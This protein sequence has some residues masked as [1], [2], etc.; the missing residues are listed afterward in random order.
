MFAVFHL[1]H[2]S[3]PF[4]I[5]LCEYIRNDC[6]KFFLFTLPERVVQENHIRIDHKLRF[7]AK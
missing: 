3:Q 5:V 7:P 4:V 1:L 6:Y 2:L